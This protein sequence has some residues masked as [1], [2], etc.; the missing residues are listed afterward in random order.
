[1]ALLFPC[2]ARASYIDA[3]GGGLIFQV[4]YLIFTGILIF[5]AVPLKNVANFFRKKKV[6]ENHPAGRD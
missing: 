1:M 3:V 6:E 2:S 5:L 4:G